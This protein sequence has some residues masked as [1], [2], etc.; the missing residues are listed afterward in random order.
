[1]GHLVDLGSWGFRALSFFPFSTAVGLLAFALVLMFWD[2][3]F[4]FPRHLLRVALGRSR[5]A[6]C[7]GQV[8][9]GLVVV[10]TLL[11][12]RDELTALQATLESVWSNG[13]PNDLVIVASIDGT[14]A[15]PALFA[16]LARWAEEQRLPARTWLHVTGTRVR[17]G[18]PLAIDHAVEHVK[19]LVAA[20]VHPT[21]PRIYFSTDADADLG[22][23]AL[24]R[25]AQR[26]CRR[27]PI[28]GSPAR[29]VAGNLYIRGNN[30]WRGWRHFFTV[31]G[32]LSIQIA[33]E[34]LVTNLGRYNIRPFPLSGLTGVLY[35]TWTDIFLEIPRFMGYMRTLTIR[36]WLKWWIGIAPPSFAA[37]TAP[38]LPELIAGDTDDTVS[39]FVATIARWERGRFT[40]EVPR[41]PLHALYFMLRTW[42]VDRPLAYEP[43]ARVYTSSPITI[44][45]L[46]KQRV[47]WNT[48]RIEVMG[49]FWPSLWFHWGL[50]AA[51][52]GV[53]MLI[54]KY[55]FFGIVYYWRAPAAIVNGS[56]P[57]VAAL[58]YGIQ[59]VVYA[60]WT[61][62]C[63][64]M[65]GQRR[66][67]LLLLALPL[68]PLYS[69]VF[70]LF[71]TLYGAIRDIFLFGNVTGFAPEATLIAGG[72]SRIA[73]AYRLRR[74]LALLWRSVRR[75]DVPLGLFWF[76]WSETP[77][78]PNGYAGWTTAKQT[79]KR[80]R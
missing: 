67:F 3:A 52:V 46:F 60:A 41:T 55:C 16:E 35:C 24:E 50:G 48:A 51:A 77:W 29:A 28:T 64:V 42:L 7:R 59:L 18:K 54:L 80:S 72:S 2:Y 79:R 44:R 11:R 74:A 68:A 9:S 76:G 45:S 26:L 61:L 14:D 71:A 78:T 8:P 58:G 70:S 43:E 20:G 47:R 23:R 5:S 25:I 39:A 38:P 22:E 57:L 31:E 65:N 56:W 62:M 30:F 63:L 32:Q 21:F 69:T 10:P 34:Y 40:L 66:H 19:A 37:S 4:L 13:Y 36:D 33:R 75:G 49:R 1:M 12:N 27:H 6:H 73:L 15:A 17:R 53:V